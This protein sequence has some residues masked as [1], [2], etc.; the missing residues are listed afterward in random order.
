MRIRWWWPMLAWCVAQAA[1][2]DEAALMLN[3]RKIVT[4]RATL[5]GQSPQERVDAARQAVDAAVA[6][7]G[8]D[9]VELQ[10]LP[11]EPP[12]VRLLVNGTA[13]FHLVP[14]DLGGAQAASLLG[15]AAQ[16]AERRLRQALAEARE[17]RD[18]RAWAV[19]LGVTLVTTAA[20][21]GA[22]WGLA[23]LRRRV[24]RRLFLWLSHDGAPAT[25]PW[26]QVSGEHA[27]ALLRGLAGLASWGVALVVLDL[28]A[29]FVLRQF[30]V[31]RVWGERAGNWLLSLLLDLLQ[32]SAAAVPGLV[33]AALIFLVARAVLRVVHAVLERVQRGE[34]SLAGLDADT[35]RP[36]SRLAGLVIWLFALAMAYPYLPG[37]SSEAFKGVTV[38]AGLMVSLGASGVVGQLMAGLS[39]MYSRALRVGEYVRIGEMEGTVTSLGMFA[40]K[41][42]TGLGEEVSLPNAVVFGQS[43]RNFSRLVQ[44][45]G[46]YVL[47]TAVTIGY[48]TPWRQVH[49]MLLEA[50]RRTPGVLE[51][52]APYVVQTALS[53][54]YVEYR[55]CAQGSRAVPQRRAEAMS[56]LHGHIQDVFN[57][58]GVQIMSPHYLGD[59]PEAQVVPAGPWFTPSAGPMPPRR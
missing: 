1:W 45:D 35:A 29:S 26:W 37:A 3:Q 2:A 15:V 51:A 46:Q 53:D 58:N 19:G 6:T 16:D 39:L 10:A 5:K 44:D 36:T 42:H 12:T 11:G 31:T 50:A 18:P 17:A 9:R 24:L 41:L 7:A 43:I 33:T 38:L 22:L 4:L 27:I 28:W 52:P 8:A 21:A 40:T 49:A 59:P 55:L 56:Q 14:E 32:A 30:A 20:A 25:R 13:V 48:T 23:A 47:H 54:F 34:L 57:E